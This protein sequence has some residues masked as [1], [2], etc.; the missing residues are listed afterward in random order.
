VILILFR[1]W[2]SVLKLL[3]CGLLGHETTLSHN[4]HVTLVIA[5]LLSE[6]PFRLASNSFVAD[7]MA[8]SCSNRLSI[9]DTNIAKHNQQKAVPSVSER[10]SGPK[11]LDWRQ[12]GVYSPASESQKVNSGRYKYRPGAI[13]AY[14]SIKGKTRFLGSKRR[15]GATF[16]EIRQCCVENQQTHNDHILEIFVQYHLRR[17]GRFEQPR[18]RGP[19]LGQCVSKRMRRRV[20]YC[21][22]PVLLKTAGGLG[23]RKPARSGIL[24]RCGGR[25]WWFNCGSIT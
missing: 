24:N 25:D 22:G 5:P 4:A 6:D 2:K 3:V 11:G 14:G 18:D 15:L 17:Y 10:E 19:E 1:E 7:E 12:T 23:G 21:I 20:K 13:A 9:A 8:A 16:L